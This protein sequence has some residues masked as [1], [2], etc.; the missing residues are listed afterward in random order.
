MEWNGYGHMDMGLKSALQKLSARQIH[1][2]KFYIFKDSSNHIE[3]KNFNQT[4]AQNM[5][6][7][8][9]EFG[10]VNKPNFKRNKLMSQVVETR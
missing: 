7:K 2:N 3:F 4:K 8:L 6:K 10:K 5:N 9:Q 1:Y